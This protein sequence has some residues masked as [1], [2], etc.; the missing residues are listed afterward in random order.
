MPA[1]LHAINLNTQLA[2][3]L[4]FILAWR[5]DPGTLDSRVL[6]GAL[7]RAYDAYFDRLVDGRPPPSQPSEDGAPPPIIQPTLCHSCHI[8]RPLR[9]KHCR[10][11]RKCVMVYDHW[12]PYISNTVGIYNYRFFFAY[13]FLFTVAALQWQYVAVVYHR[14]HGTDGTLLA[15]QIW[16][17]PFILF[18]LAMV[19]YHSQLTYSNLTTNEH[20]NYHRYDYFRDDAARKFK[21]PFDR[22]CLPNLIDRFFPKPLESHPLIMQIAQFADDLPAAHAKI[23]ATGRVLDV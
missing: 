23:T 4:A 9:A 14:R 13:C 3:W 17:A 6:G 19:C 2:T 18:G 15:A 8:Q 16:F 12:C 5:C 21:N 22:G 20:I 7:R 11:R 1:V 10:V